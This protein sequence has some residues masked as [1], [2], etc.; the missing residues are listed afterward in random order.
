M[1]ISTFQW[2]YCQGFTFKRCNKID[3]VVDVCMVSV[4][5]EKL[6]W[7]QNSE[8]CNEDFWLVRRLGSAADRRSPNWANQGT[9][10]DAIKGI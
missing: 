4:N 9:V 7:R 3:K 6:A 1:M 2:E 8:Y 5:L 10:K